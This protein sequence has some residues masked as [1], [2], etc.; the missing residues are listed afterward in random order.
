MGSV[1]EAVVRRFYEEMCNGRRNGIAAELFTADHVLR[2]PQVPAR[3][4]PEG[5]AEVISAYQQGVN[6]HWQIEELLSAAD[7]VVARWTGTGTHVAAMNGI[8]AT[9]RPIRVDA[10]SI[11]RIRDGKIAETIEVWDTLS[12]LQQI[13]ALPGAGTTLVRSGYAAFARGDVAAVLALFDPRITWISPDTFGSGGTYTGPAGVGE[14]FSH[15]PEYY[16]ELNVVPERFV[17]QG[18]QV[19]ALGSLRGRSV[20]GAQFDLPFVHCW[21]V[22]DGKITRFDEYFDTV[23]ANATLGLPGAVELLSSVTIPS[24]L[25]LTE[26]GATAAR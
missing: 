22:A 3:R 14:F 17:E 18:D 10:I 20:S 6:G 11:H 19:I 5:M 12:F 21:T 13:S 4:G 9:G 25:N 16:A 24:Q 26:Q 1:E 8:P 15:L 23:R 7:R 2:D